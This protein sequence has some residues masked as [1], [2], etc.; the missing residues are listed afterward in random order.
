LPVAILIQGLERGGGIGDFVRAEDTIVVCVE[1][2]DQRHRR[3]A[4]AGA[5]SGTAGRAIRRAAVLSTRAGATRRWPVI[6]SQ[7]S[8]GWQGERQRE[9][10]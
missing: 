9:N 5:G 2:K 3:R 6:L 7:E 8:A 1:R 4:P 10:H